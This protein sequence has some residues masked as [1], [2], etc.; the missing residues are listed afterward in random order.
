[1]SDVSKPTREAVDAARLP[2]A[3]CRSV[4]LLLRV[5]VS[6]KN[7]SNNS[8][9]PSAC[10]KSSCSC[11]FLHAAVMLGY[12]ASSVYMPAPSADNVMFMPICRTSID[13]SLLTYSSG[14]VKIP[15]STVIGLVTRRIH[16]RRIG[17][18]SKTANIARATHRF[19]FQRTQL[20]TCVVNGSSFP[21]PSIQQPRPC[22]I[23]IADHGPQSP[24]QS[25]NAHPAPMSRALIRCIARPPTNL[26]SIL[27]SFPISPC[28]GTRRRPVETP[29]LSS[30]HYTDPS[31][32][33]HTSPS[34]T[35]GILRKTKM[36]THPISNMTSRR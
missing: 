31:H 27:P 5:C 10:T 13:A 29:R 16:G 22:S 8:G 32:R 12:Y 11:G 17:Y 14:M 23:A 25:T 20:Q 30:P 1:M 33:Q 4:P 2:T 26:Y 15:S 36:T 35:S 24:I 3:S 18:F 28:G 21:I 7:N 9:L 34:T 6:R 19:F